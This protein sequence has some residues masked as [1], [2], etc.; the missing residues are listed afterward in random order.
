MLGDP[1][2]VA[3][4]RSQVTK[5]IVD[6][7]H[8]M[9]AAASMTKIDRHENLPHDHHH[10]VESCD[11]FRASITQLCNPDIGNQQLAVSSG[12]TAEQQHITGSF[13]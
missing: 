3:I 7:Q 12:S 9:S 10:D 4:S 5:A 6:S 11:V 13:S 8:R 1:V 2:M